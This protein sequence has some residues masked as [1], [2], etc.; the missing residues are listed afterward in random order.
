MDTSEAY[1]K[2]LELLNAESYLD[3]PNRA[4]LLKGLSKKS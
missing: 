1:Q 3:V 2:E 4:E